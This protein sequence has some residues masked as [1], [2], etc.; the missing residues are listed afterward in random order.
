MKTNRFVQI[1]VV[2]CVISIGFLVFWQINSWQVKDAKRVKICANTKSLTAIATDKYEANGVKYRGGTLFRK[3]ALQS[4]RTIPVVIFPQSLSPQ[5]WLKF[6]QS[7]IYYL[8]WGG[9]KSWQ[10]W[11]SSDHFYLVEVPPQAKGLA[12]SRLCYRNGDVGVHTIQK[13]EKL[14]P[15]KIV[16]NNNIEIS[17][18]Q[19]LPE[20]NSSHIIVNAGSDRRDFLGGKTEVYFT[21]TEIK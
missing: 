12:F 7:S 18:N 8:G 13:L 16:I 6:P 11:L 4:N 14:S 15:Q 9:D 10:E 2:V 5:V 21:T 17:L 20:I 1:L 3:L 19:P